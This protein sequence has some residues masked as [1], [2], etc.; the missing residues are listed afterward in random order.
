MVRT[1][2]MHR[3]PTQNRL[4]VIVTL[5]GMLCLCTIILLPQARPKLAVEPQGELLSQVSS[6]PAL[7]A[8]G[9]HSFRLPLHA[10]QYIELRVQQL[11]MDVQVR[12]LRSNGEQACDGRYAMSKVVVRSPGADDSLR[13]ATHQ[14][15]REGIE[16]Y[17]AR[18]TESTR[19][20]IPIF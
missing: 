6:R 5:I 4:T 1:V 13:V 20:S 8:G 17:F 2:V 15:Y 9:A 11:A 14:A 18:N 10:N 19:K 3:K 16:L 12:L 7:K